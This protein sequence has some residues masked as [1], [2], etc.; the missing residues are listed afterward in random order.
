MVMHIM[1]ATC[2]ACNNLGTTI[3]FVVNVVMKIGVFWTVTPC[4]LLYE[5]AYV[6]VPPFYLCKE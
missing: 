5:Y 2:T 6:S 4:L 3:E 1:I